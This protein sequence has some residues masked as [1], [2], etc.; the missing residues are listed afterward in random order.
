MKKD[1][2]KKDDSIEKEYFEEIELTDPIT[3]KK[4][5]QKVKITRYKTLSTNNKSVIEELE[6]DNIGVLPDDM[7]IEDEE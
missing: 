4:F 6:E 7:S 5:L 3:G 2:K 1:K